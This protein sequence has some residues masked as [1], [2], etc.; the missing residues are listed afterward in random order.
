[1]SVP[2]L[3]LCGLDPGPAVALAAGALLTALADDRAVRPVL[4]GVDLPLWRLLHGST[5]RAP[6]LLDPRLVD[7][8]VA[9]ELL[10]EWG[11][12]GDLTVVIAAEPAL[13]RWEGVKGSRPLDVA[14][15]L[16]APL[17]LVVDA[18]ERGATVGAWALGLK[19]LARELEFAGV[20]VV[21]GDEQGRATGLRGLIEDIAR[22]P[23]LGW[24]PPQLSEQFARQYAGPRGQLRQIGP[25][26]V[27][28]GE[29]ALCREAAGY[30]DRLAIEAAAARRGFLPAR[31]RR[32]LAPLPAAEGL[33]LAVA[34]GPPLEPFALEAIDVFKALGLGLEPL[35]LEKDGAMPA[36]VAGLCIAGLLDEERLDAFAANE[37]LKSAIAEA[38]ASGLPTLALGG[39]ALLLLRRLT[40]SRGR[41][42][43]LAGVLPGEAELLEWY[44][45][46]RYVSAA[47]APENPYLQG[48]ATLY[49][50]FDLEFLTLEQ[51]GSAWLLGAGEDGQVEGFVHE[52]CLATTLIPSVP[53]TPELAAGFVAAMR[54]SASGA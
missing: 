51:E 3:V 30:L 13:D 17:L 9:G 23:V 47:A 35:R 43:E 16:D 49:E 34:W 11:A 21:G 20:I 22:L 7:D 32:L 26:P 19:L 5:A 52:R 39:G 33:K 10:D 44:E 46:P 12:D 36:D 18:R 50:L 8:A 4:L 53:A 15:A 37:T 25:Q 29:A 31:P 28:G 27:K 48:D 1:M 41:T 40:D 38:V 6:R 42:H 45:R 24:L 14:L 2:R 54:Q